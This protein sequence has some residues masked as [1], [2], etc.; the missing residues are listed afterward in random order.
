[1]NVG[2]HSHIDH[3]SR[4]ERFQR[5]SRLNNS[6]SNLHPHRSGNLKRSAS[7]IRNLSEF[8]ES[9][10][11]LKN[12][13]L[14][15]VSIEFNLGRHGSVTIREIIEDPGIRAIFLRKVNKKLFSR[16]VRHLK[17][18]IQNQYRAFL[19]N[20]HVVSAKNF[21]KEHLQAKMWR[22][23]LKILNALCKI[24]LIPFAGDIRNTYSAVKFLR[25]TFSFVE[26][27][28]FKGAGTARVFAHRSFKASYTS[29][30]LLTNSAKVLNGHAWTQMFYTS[31]GLGNDFRPLPDFLTAFCEEISPAIVFMKLCLKSHSLK[32]AICN[33]YTHNIED[34]ATDLTNKRW[35]LVRRSAEFGGELTK[36]YIRV[37]SGGTASPVLIAADRLLPFAS[38][39]CTVT[40]AGISWRQ[41]Y[42]KRP[43]RNDNDNVQNQT[44]IFLEYPSPQVSTTID[45]VQPL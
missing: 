20:R 13:I 39:A 33:Y 21:S 18:N 14:R 38:I 10:N 17:R 27:L 19:A 30:S 5:S 11:R 25:K 15:I 7:D 32:Q 1:M 22:C 26:S 31:I 9:Y 41:I 8:D 35:E 23:L 4:A 42:V 29:L 45:S 37:A 43:V 44:E 36:I 12:L 24:L 16:N 40:S 2:T 6:Y 34:S 28:N 3:A